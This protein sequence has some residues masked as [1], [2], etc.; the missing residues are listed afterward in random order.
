MRLRL[1]RTVGLWLVLTSVVAAICLAGLVVAALRL[2][3][4]GLP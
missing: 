3:A 2:I 4:S 1:N